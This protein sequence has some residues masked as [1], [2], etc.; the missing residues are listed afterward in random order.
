M[1]TPCL[2][3]SPTTKRLTTAPSAGQRQLKPLLTGVGTA[4]GGRAAVPAELGGA[5]GALPGRAT[6]VPLPLPPPGGYSFNDCPG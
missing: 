1:S 6:T 5:T 2:V 3:V 4:T